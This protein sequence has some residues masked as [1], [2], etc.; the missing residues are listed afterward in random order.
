[1][2][3]AD[4][5][6]KQHRAIA[7]QSG[8]LLGLSVWATLLVFWLLLSGIYTTFLIAAGIGCAAAVVGLA[9]RMHLIDIEGHPIRYALRAVL[10]YWPWLVKEI[11]KSAWQ[12]SLVILHPRLPI[13]PQ[14]VRFK[15]SQRSEV[16][17]VIHANSITLTP[18]TMTIEAH[19]DEFLVH[20]LTADTAAGVGTDSEMDQRVARMEGDL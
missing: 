9:M 14:V 16:G 13:S 6:R 17:L 19:P 15:P 10:W 1:M 3:S 5:G 20:A 12:V 7:G 8:A 4:R 2:S 18:G 11:V